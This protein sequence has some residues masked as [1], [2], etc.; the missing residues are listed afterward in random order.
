[1]RVDGMKA[2][3]GSGTRCAAK[4]W[5]LAHSAWRRSAVAI[6]CQYPIPSTAPIPYRLPGGE[7]MTDGVPLVAVMLRLSTSA[8]EAT[9]GGGR[10]YA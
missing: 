6:C 4:Q 7:W 10:R 5:Q 2:D 1:M 9:T 8:E 3:V